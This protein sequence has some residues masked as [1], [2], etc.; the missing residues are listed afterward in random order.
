MFDLHYFWESFTLFR[1][2]RQKPS[3]ME[4]YLSY[5]KNYSSP[6]FMGIHGEHSFIQQMVG[7]AG[8]DFVYMSLRSAAP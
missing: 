2:S 4:M 1:V 7:R 6:L 3:S 8:E 5:I